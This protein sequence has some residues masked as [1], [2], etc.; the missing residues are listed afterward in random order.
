MAA[1]SKPT[2]LLFVEIAEAIVE[3]MDLTGNS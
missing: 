3:G 2:N 1:A